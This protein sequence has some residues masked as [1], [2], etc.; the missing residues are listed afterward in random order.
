MVSK[1]NLS[2]H[3]RRLILDNVG[4]LP[5][6]LIAKLPKGLRKDYLHFYPYGFHALPDSLALRYKLC[7]Q[8]TKILNALQQLRDAWELSKFITIDQEMSSLI[9]SYNSDEEFND[10]IDSLAPR[11]IT[12]K[13]TSVLIKSD[14]MSLMNSNEFIIA[15]DVSSVLTAEVVEPVE[16]DVA[17]AIRSAREVADTIAL[18]SRKEII[19]VP[20]TSRIYTSPEVLRTIG[21]NRFKCCY[22]KK[23]YPSEVEASDAIAHQYDVAVRKGTPLDVEISSYLCPYCSLW[24]KAKSSTVD[25]FKRNFVLSV[26]TDLKE[27]KEEIEMAR[28]IQRNTVLLSLPG[29]CLYA[30]HM[31]GHHD[32]KGLS[33]GVIL[34]MLR[35]GLAEFEAYNPAEGVLWLDRQGNR[36]I[37]QAYERNIMNNSIVLKT[38]A[39]PRI[40]E[41]FNDWKNIQNKSLDVCVDE[42]VETVDEP[43]ETVEPERIIKSDTIVR[44]KPAVVSE[45]ETEPVITFFGPVT[46]YTPVDDNLKPSESDALDFST[47]T[48][49]LL[50]NDIE[51]WREKYEAC[52]NVLM[53]V[54][55]HL[56]NGKSGDYV[57][58][59]LDIK[60]PSL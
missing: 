25:W 26:P 1:A 24:H 40:L 32:L 45:H 17:R 10:Y 4:E 52:H 22:G 58:C 39:V 7:P 36:A 11:K 20:E 44:C 56:E 2:Q 6:D 29:R 16:T 30:I 55:T 19:I 38:N 34:Q 23:G 60:L 28:E 5:T 50:S 43:V 3:Q 31:K 35:Q 57:H 12:R 41:L 47:V 49:Q 8:S 21:V 54:W 18:S 53:E 51:K 42:T 37:T 48:A 9:C 46:P 33:I 15:S 14:V 27:Y 59:L 13:G